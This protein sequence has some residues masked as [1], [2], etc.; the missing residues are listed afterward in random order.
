MSVPVAMVVGVVSLTIA[1]TSPRTEAVHIQGKGCPVITGGGACVIACTEGSCLNGQ[2]CCSTGCGRI[3]MDSADIDSM[4]PAMGCTLQLSLQ[5]Q[6]ANGDVKVMKDAAS[7]A[8]K[9]APQ[10]DSSKL[11]NERIIALTYN[12]GREGDCCKTRDVLAVN[13]AT[14]KSV[15]FDG[16]AP[17]QCAS[18][19]VVSVH[20]HDSPWASAGVI[21]T[22][23]K[24]DG[25]H[26][27]MPGGVSPPKPLDET[28]TRVWQ[29]VLKHTPK[30]NGV[31][32]KSL[33]EPVSVRV[34]VVAGM[35]Y[36]YAFAGGRNVTVWDQSWAPPPRVTKVE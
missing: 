20:E 18:A 27:Q 12:V 35:N 6:F 10:P 5:D 36:M 29:S 1:I 3:C 25:T 2:L 15:K 7:A 21:E 17:P 16:I 31:D 11:T 4:Q 19:S 26:E 34:Q 8:M 13:T 24:E 30:Y 22:D 33:G 14:V 9:G 28:T 23:S 32:L